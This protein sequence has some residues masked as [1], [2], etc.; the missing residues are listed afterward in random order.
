[1]KKIVFLFLI[2]SFNVLFSMQKKKNIN[3]FPDIYK[4]VRDRCFNKNLYKNLRNNIGNISQ[5]KRDRLQG[6]CDRDLRPFVLKHFL[7]LSPYEPGVDFIKKIISE[8]PVQDFGSALVFC[9]SKKHYWNVARYILDNCF[10]GNNEYIKDFVRDA[11][12]F[13]KFE[14]VEKILCV[15][16]MCSNIDFINELMSLNV[17]G[18]GNVFIAGFLLLLGANFKNE[19]FFD[20]IKRGNIDLVKFFLE[21]IRGLKKNL[22][23]N[24][25]R[26]EESFG[27][28][29]HVAML[30][31]RNK[32]HMV[33]LLVSL[34]VSLYAIDSKGHT[35]LESLLFCGEDFSSE[36]AEV[37]EIFLSMDDYC[38]NEVNIE[39]VKNTREPNYY[40]DI[41]LDKIQVARSESDCKKYNL[42][43]LIRSIKDVKIEE[44][45]KI[46]LQE[47]KQNY[48][49][50]FISSVHCNRIDLIRYFL[51]K[52]ETNIGKSAIVNGI[53]VAI[54]KGYEEIFWELFHCLEDIDEESLIDFFSY[55]AAKNRVKILEFLIEDIED[56]PLIAFQ[57]A[58]DEAASH[59]HADSIIKLKACNESLFNSLDLMQAAVLAITNGH[60]DTLKCLFYLGAQ[61]K[62]RILS[63]ALKSKNKEIVTFIAEDI[64]GSRLFLEK[65]FFK[66]FIYKNMILTNKD[67]EMFD[68]LLKNNL[69]RLKINIDRYLEKRYEYLYTEDELKRIADDIESRHLL[70]NN[71]AKKKTTKKDILKNL[72]VCEKDKN[73]KKKR[74]TCENDE[75]RHRILNKLSD[76]LK[77]DKEKA[78]KRKKV[79]RQAPPSAPSA[80]LR[81]TTDKQDEKKIIPNFSR[82]LFFTEKPSNDEDGF[83]KK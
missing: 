78:D 62:L 6:C 79:L 17:E 83:L 34:G 82:G 69:V 8:N 41:I 52:K 12:T 58:L 66:Y 53:S 1:M 33:R 37:A 26:D 36:D 74:V 29:L 27:N 75:I 30:S 81:T 35:P 46:I 25:L 68:I 7:E 16:Y 39:L 60:A 13:G 21:K 15:P 56:V 40:V 67:E 19:L 14:F 55:A 65:D 42:S 63:E 71:V 23:K 54:D 3:V 72:C 48:A 32:T 70:K 4:N 59:G 61:D 10:I 73:K 80:K 11:A 2:L 76:S 49:Q 5:E 18:E 64:K 50:A 45:E 43:W 28:A 44:V 47:P 20:A 51:E 22:S 24:M 9:G 77:E 31:E 57:V 38:A